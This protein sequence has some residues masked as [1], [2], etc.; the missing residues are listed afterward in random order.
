LNDEAP[1]APRSP[2]RRIGARNKLQTSFLEDLANAWQRDGKAALTVMAREEPA[3][4]VTVCAGL[5][6]KDIVFQSMLGEIDDT[7]LDD[8]I[9]RMRQRLLDARA[10]QPPMTLITQDMKVEKVSNGK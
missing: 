1:H 4:F 9:L 5:M 6:P 3:K 2:G 8:M 10:Q 7:E